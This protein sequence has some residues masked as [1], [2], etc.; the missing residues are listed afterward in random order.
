MAENWAPYCTGFSHKIRLQRSPIIEYRYRH[1]EQYSEARPR[2]GDVIPSE[3]FVQMAPDK[4]FKSL[5]ITNLGYAALEP[6]YFE[7]SANS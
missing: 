1:F 7:S 6:Y 5:F 2:F 4:P 3:R